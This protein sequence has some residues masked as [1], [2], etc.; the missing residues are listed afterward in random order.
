MP[1]LSELNTDAIAENVLLNM[2]IREKMEWHKWWEFATNCKAPT[3]E[4]P[5]TT[6]WI[7]YVRERTSLKNAINNYSAKNVGSPKRLSAQNG[8]IFMD[9]EKT[10]TR[11]WTVKRT[12]KLANCLNTSVE[13]LN[14]FVAVIKDDHERRM[15]NRMIIAFEAQ[16][17]AIAGT[18]GRMRSL[19]KETRK[20]MLE[21]FGIDV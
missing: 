17:N 12:R 18:I 21:D 20:K 10:V 14:D 3:E 1:R 16:Q 4:M 19:P 6:E 11:T 8:H 5:H 15:L 9:D 2:P 7:Y 13:I